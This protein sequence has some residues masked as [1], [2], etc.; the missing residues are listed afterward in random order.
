MANGVLQKYLVCQRVLEAIARQKTDQ[1]LHAMRHLRK[2]EERRGEWVWWDCHLSVAK[3]AREETCKPIKQEEEMKAC[4]RV[5]TTFLNTTTTVPGADLA[6][7]S[8]SQ[9][10]AVRYCSKGSSR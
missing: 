4:G 10:K 7:T 3:G 9:C 5:S 1:D 8:L 2:D 6:R